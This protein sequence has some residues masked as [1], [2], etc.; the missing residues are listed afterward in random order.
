MYELRPNVGH[1]AAWLQRPG[2]ILVCDL[3]L[4]RFVCGGWRSS[5]CCRTASTKVVM[6]LSKI[7]PVFHFE[8]QNS[9]LPN[10]ITEP[11]WEPNFGNI[12]ATSLIV[13]IIISTTF[14]NNE[15][16]VVR[17]LAKWKKM[18]IGNPFLSVCFLRSSFRLSCLIVPKSLPCIKSKSA[19]STCDLFKVR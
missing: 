10:M 2:L 3:L 15:S 12:D 11:K 16:H 4:L 14:A 19:F 8:F 5:A 18:V 17:C 9:V 1:S 7:G 6:A 13:Y